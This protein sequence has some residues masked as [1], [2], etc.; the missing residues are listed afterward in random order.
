[1]SFSPDFLREVRARVSL[2]D[3]TS[4]RVSF[5]RHKSDPRK[6]DFWGRCPFHNEKTASFHVNDAEG[7]YYCF[8]CHETGDAIKFLER[9]ENLSFREAVENLA[10]H[11][12]LKIPAQDPKAAARQERHKS[13]SDV[14]GE[15]QKFFAD[16]LHER[17]AEAARHYLDR[18][19]CSEAL[20][21]TFGIGYAPPGQALLAHLKAKGTSIDLMIEAG[22]VALDEER[23]PYE[24]FRERIIFPIRDAQDRL[25]GF[26]GRILRTESNAPKYLNSPE[27]E[28]F[29]KGRL[30]FNYGLAKQAAR[31]SGTLILVEGYMD[32]IALYGA[33]VR[34]VVA[35]LG[36]ALTAEQLSLVWK[37]AEEPVICFDGDEAGQRAA[38]RAADLA[39]P[40]VKARQSLRFALLPAGQDPDD[41]VRG[42]GVATLEAALARPK[43]LYEFLFE[44]ECA[45]GSLDTP[46]RRADLERRLFEAARRI[47]DR[48]ARRHYEQGFRERLARLFVPTRPVQ[49]ALLNGGRAG[50]TRPGLQPGL[51]AISPA[52]RR[53]MLAQDACRERD[54]GDHKGL[55]TRT[56][57]TLPDPALVRHYLS[58]IEAALIGLILDHE[59]LLDRVAEDLGRLEPV[60]GKLDNIFQELIH[61]S[62]GAVRLDGRGL[63]DHLSTSGLGE[64]ADRSASGIVRRM[65]EQWRGQELGET[66]HAW[67]VLAER[68]LK[69]QRLRTEI[70]AAQ[71]ALEGDPG[72]AVHWHRLRA[73]MAERQ[74]LE[75]VSIWPEERVNVTDGEG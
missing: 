35:P 55:S 48:P 51:A 53:S 73:L 50:R 59:G 46:E 9:T 42:Q 61:L 67:R 31:E 22:L 40:M 75:Q 11:A 66:E 37:L 45:A 72:V 65:R 23:R 5:D 25:A 33:G 1:M 32:V 4:K 16:A 38:S 43:P 12:G 70:E 3:V 58:D 54:Q 28:L 6:R 7:F 69:V 63:K 36:T 64:A 41:L 13:I 29:S 30:L 14:L 15:A 74:V 24:R 52:L 60:S 44:R 18:R 21:N 56:H 10:A 19:G 68:H 34:H 47:E 71:L 49:S 57:S 20:R 62:S 27:T 2:A 17:G 26:G 39:L 8:G